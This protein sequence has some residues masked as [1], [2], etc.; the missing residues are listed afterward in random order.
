MNCVCPNAPAQ[1]PLSFSSGMSPL[2]AIF[3]VAISSPRKKAGRAE[4]VQASVVSDCTSGRLP[5]S[6]PKSDSMP[7]IAAIA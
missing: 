7:Q 5:I 4:F 1:E 2:S 3:S 6:R